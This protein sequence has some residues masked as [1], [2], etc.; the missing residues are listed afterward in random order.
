[1]S[2]N[3]RKSGQ[4]FQN[5]PQTVFP[6]PLEP[7]HAPSTRDSNQSARVVLLSIVQAPDGST[8]PSKKGPKT[9]KCPPKMR[10]FARLQGILTAF[11]LLLCIL[12]CEIA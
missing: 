5:G 1:M 9:R 8:K 3:V 10:F 7:F 6:A 12:I 11:R 2:S 4:P